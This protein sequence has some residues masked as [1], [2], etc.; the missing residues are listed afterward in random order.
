VAFLEVIV[1]SRFGIGCW[2]I[3]WMWLLVA[4]DGWFRS[5]CCWQVWKWLLVDCL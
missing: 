3:V 2:W 4:V 5:G 1:G